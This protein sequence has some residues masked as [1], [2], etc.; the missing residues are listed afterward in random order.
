MEPSRVSVEN[1][2]FSGGGIYYY[3]IQ[4]GEFQDVK[5][6]ELIKNNIEYGT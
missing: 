2:D 6:L 3:L 5:K 4:S 1:P